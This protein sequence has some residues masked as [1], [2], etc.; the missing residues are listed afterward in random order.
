MILG[1]LLIHLIADYNSVFPAGGTVAASFDRALWYQRGYDM[2]SEHRDKGSDVQLGPVVGPIGRSPEG[3]RNWEGFSPDPV[4]SGFAVAESVKGI[5]DA[6]VIACTKHFIANEQEHFRQAGEAAGYGFNITESIS[7]NIDDVTMHELYLWPFADAVRAG[8]GS[9]MCSYQQINNSYGCSNSYT[10]NYLLKGELGF[11]GFI[12]SDWGAQHSGVGTALAGLDMSMPGDASFDSGTSF[13]GGNLTI[14]VLNGTIPEWRIDDM[15][16][17]IMA[18]FYYVG[19]D[20]VQVPINFDSWTLDTYSY[21]HYVAQEGYQIV[22]E[23]VDV[24]GNHAQ[25]IRSMAAR[26]TV[27]LKN[28]GKILPLSGKEKFTAII[29]EDAGANEYG[30][31]GCGDR[32]CDNG[33]LAEG[34]GSGTANFANLVTPIAGISNAIYAAGN[35]VVQAIT[36]NYAT[37]Q[38]ASLA[39]QATV[40][41]VFVNADSGEGYISVDGNEGDR[42]NLTLWHG[43]DGLIANVSAICNNTIVIIHSPG[44]VLLT[45]FYD[46]PNVTGIIWAGMPGDQ[47][48]NSI[49]DVLYG[50]VNPGAKLPFTL[51]ARRQ[52]YGTDL[53]Y[54][55]NNGVLA[56]QDNFAEGVFIDY[57]HFDKADIEPI[58]EFGFGLSYTEFSITNLQVHS[59]GITPY[60]PTTG[61]TAA[62]PVLGAAGAAADDVY[63]AGFHQVPLYIYPYINSTN[64]AASSNDPNY[65]LPTSSYVPA[66]AQDGSP[67][68]R[69]AAGGAPGGNPALYDVLFTVTATVTNT[70]AVTGDEVPQLY[71]NLGGPGD[72]KVVLRNFERLTIAPGQTATF[73]ADI[74]RR[75]IS[76]WDTVTQNW[77]ITN[78]P[79]TVFVGSSSRSLPLN[80]TLPLG[81]AYGGSSSSSSSSASGKATSS[82]V[83]SAT[84]KSSS[85]APASSSSAPASSG[86]APASSSASASSSAP[87]S[88]TAA[89]S[90]SPPA[91][92]PPGYQS[93]G[94]GHH[95]P[96]TSGW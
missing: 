62:A 49:A 75:D 57:R 54:R 32:G 63:P 66:G 41:L 40:A 8:T 33:T 60:A 81:P 96:W 83:S 70:G 50:K 95:G 1:C 58:Y 39:S 2:G 7:A 28:S 76:N 45:E 77:V 10:M 90:Y 36:D 71:I 22:N 51:G 85:S 89:P 92:G 38:I 68:P 52:D 5:Q 93:H 31:N 20:K 46:N 24:R 18:A 53:L 79:K 61:Q 37:S 69:V 19:R 59:N 88:T 25:D 9:I 3:G 26:S 55:P 17:R 86:S 80:A 56:P 42:N 27:L 64:L 44:P 65:G 84:D 11:Q 48:G 67:Q 72:P 15:A 87:A 6:G 14:A 23:H 91:Y 73:N 78:Y 82:V 12:M 16:T 21:V 94:W 34:W 35:G 43:G 30:P 74:T 47:S 4:L 13:W 29:G